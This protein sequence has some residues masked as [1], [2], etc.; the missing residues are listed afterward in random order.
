MRL[1]VPY[2]EISADTLAYLEGRWHFRV[3]LRGPHAYDRYLTQQWKRGES[4][5]NLEHDVVPHAGAL[6]ELE[7]CD[8]PWCAFGYQV[9]HDLGVG[10]TLGFT[11]LGSELMEALPEIWHDQHDRHWRNCD[12]HL[13]TAARA[14]GLAVHQ[15][16][17]HV[18]NGMSLY[19]GAL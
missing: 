1:Y 2:T 12:V 8:R 17:P 9:D 19:P 4:F 6:S 5:V 14:K 15:H 16:Y 18:I 7:A 10:A 13:Y 3:R 11:K